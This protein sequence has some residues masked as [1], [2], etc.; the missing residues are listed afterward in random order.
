MFLNISDVLD[1]LGKCEYITTIDLT[2]GFHQI[3]T[4]PNDVTKNSFSC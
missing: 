4:N 2:N 1:Q 3:E